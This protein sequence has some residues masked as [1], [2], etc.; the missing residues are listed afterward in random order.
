LDKKIRVAV[1]GT[2]EI[3]TKAHIPAYLSNKDIDLV[4]LVDIDQRKVKMAAKRFGIRHF[5]LSVDEMFKN[6][7]VD[8]V[9]ICT[10]PDTHAEVTLKALACGA[11]V[12]CEKPL[13]T[14]IDE[15]RK[16]VEAW[17]TQGRILMVGFNRR[18]QPNYQSARNSILRGRLGHIYC[19]EDHLLHR[20]PL[21][22]WG[23]SRWFYK[24]GVGGVILDLGPHAVDILNYLFRDFPIAVTAIATT[25]LDSPVEECCVFVLEYPKNKTGVAIISWLSSRSIENIA[26]HGTAQSLYVSPSL[27]LKVNPTDI[28]E[29]SLW[30]KTTEQLIGM[31]FPHLVLSPNWHRNI[32]TYRMEI[33]NFVAHIKDNRTTCSNAIDAL[34]VLITCNAIKKASEINK[35]IEISSLMRGPTDF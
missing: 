6:V 28:P 9:S 25:Y 4:A 18:F 17:K 20:S 2:G 8:A 30:R 7:N 24:P 31:K 22:A 33:N 13:A 34:N 21:L 23:K 26:I 12:L 27:F 35:R 10:P 32:D 3:A 5:F 16:M 11:H 1:I 29:I 15:G 14:N 19:V